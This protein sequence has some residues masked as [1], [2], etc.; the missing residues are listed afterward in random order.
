M[1]NAHA[2]T[3][4]RT[5]R[6]RLERV[7]YLEEQHN[8]AAE[9]EQAQLLAARLLHR[10]LVDFLVR[11]RADAAVRQIAQIGTAEVARDG[12]GL[13][14]GVKVY[15]NGAHIVRAHRRQRQ[16]ALMHIKK[17]VRYMFITCL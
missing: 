12:V 6:R 3:R 17:N 15:H 5:P 1:Q 8:G 13:H 9:I 14:L 11:V 10:R 7:A 16:E 2:H 4:T